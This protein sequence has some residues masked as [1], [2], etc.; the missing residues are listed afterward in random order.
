MTTSPSSRSSGGLDQRVADYDVS[1]WYTF[2]GC[3][4]LVSGFIN[5]MHG[6]IA[7]AESD[8]LVN[9]LYFENLDVWGWVFLGFGAL[10]L[11][12]G[13]MSLAMR[14]L[15]PII[16]VTLASIAMILW[17]AMIFAAPFPALVGIAI[18]GTIIYGLTRVEA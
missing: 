6:Y 17:F 7:I 5:A 18:N 16:G 13:G 9:Q 12:A 8:Y 2:A 4:L 11:L 15:G 14:T 1:G 10:Q 3:M